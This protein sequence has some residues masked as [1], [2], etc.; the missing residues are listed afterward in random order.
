MNLPW[1]K[2]I[3][4]TRIS[5]LGLTVEGSLYEALPEGGRVS[6]SSPKGIGNSHNMHKSPPLVPLRN[7][8]LYGI[9]EQI[10]QVSGGS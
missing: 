6:P 10:F 4:L 1:V 7:I 3:S 8:S 5:R 2:Q 9:W